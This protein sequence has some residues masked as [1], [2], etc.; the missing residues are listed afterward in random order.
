MTASA[1]TASTSGVAPERPEAAPLS[2]EAG[3]VR[4]GAAGDRAALQAIVRAYQ[5]RVYGLLLKLSGDR[6]LALDLAQETFL[7]AF[8]AL[9]GFRQGASLGPWLFKIAHNLFLDHVRKRHPESLDAWLDAGVE[10][11]AVDASIGRIDNDV[12]LPAAMA[13]LPPGW[14]QA[15]ALRYEADMPY[16]AIAETL[17]VPVGT[18]KTWLF[19]GRDRLRAILDQGASS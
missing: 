15:I 5:D 16:E 18:V 12:D 14:R 10:P 6:E 7:K 2:L 17:E 1:A 8:A 19:R 4:R 11:G 13:Q 3:W 9:A